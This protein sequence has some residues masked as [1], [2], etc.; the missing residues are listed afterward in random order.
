M[1]KNRPASAGD[2]RG[3]GSIATR[4]FLPGKSH[5]QRSLAATVHGVCQELDVTEHAPYPN[6]ETIMPARLGSCLVKTALS[7]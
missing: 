6:T 5:G 1:V 2:A 4:A 3:V 7:T